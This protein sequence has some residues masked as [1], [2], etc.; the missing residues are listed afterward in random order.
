MKRFSRK[1][2][3]FV[4]QRLVL[5]FDEGGLVRRSNRRQRRGDVRPE[6]QFLFPQAEVEVVEA[7][8]GLRDLLLPAEA[9]EDGKADRNARRR[10][11]AGK[12]ER[13]T[14]ILIFYAPCVLIRELKLRAFLRGKRVRQPGKKIV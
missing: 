7:Y 8:L 6:R 5:C 14:G 2:E 4:S 11:L 12:A 1:P 9:L 13:E 3:L 10:W